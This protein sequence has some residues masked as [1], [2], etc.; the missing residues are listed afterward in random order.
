MKD[1]CGADIMAKSTAR[2]IEEQALLEYIKKKGVALTEVRVAIEEYL[3]KKKK[4][5]ERCKDTLEFP[6]SNPEPRSK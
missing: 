1:W 5:E 4:L 2:F 3:A 6:F